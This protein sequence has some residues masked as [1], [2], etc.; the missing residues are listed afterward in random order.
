MLGEDLW[1]IKLPLAY[2]ETLG[3]VSLL[4]RPLLIKGGLK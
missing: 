4:S 1:K 3:E 2:C